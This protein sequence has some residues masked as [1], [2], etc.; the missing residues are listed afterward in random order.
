[1]ARWLVPGVLA[2]LVPLA[3]AAPVPLKPEPRLK[4][5]VLLPED[6][7]KI[8][9][10][11]EADALDPKAPEGIAPKRG[12]VAL[13]LHLSQNRYRMGQ[14]IPALFAVKNLTKKDL[15]L[16]FRLDLLETPPHFA[17]SCSVF[18]RNTRTNSNFSLSNTKTWECGSGALCGVPAEGFLALRGDLG[19]TP[20]GPLPVGDYV[21]HWTYGRLR[22]NAVRFTVIE[23]PTDGNPRPA[24]VV[25]VLNVQSEPAGQQARMLKKIEIE[26]DNRIEILDGTELAPVST[27]ELVQA[28]GA[29]VQGQHYPHLNEIPEED[30]LLRIRTKW[31]TVDKRDYVTIAF[32]SKNPDR[33]VSFQQMPTVFLILEGAGETQRERNQQEAKADRLDEKRA[34]LETPVSVEVRL[35]PNWKA[36]AGLSGPVRVSVLA[37]S[38]APNLDRFALKRL[39]Q[40]EKIK[41]VE[42]T[43]IWNG[44]LRSSERE[45]DFPQ[46][47]AK[48]PQ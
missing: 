20:N 39:Q 30:D 43:P 18:I 41:F 47:R 35:V 23:S 12:E 37:M 15:G 1:M 6:L 14:S 13:G 8:P 4:H 32:E 21:C 10:P 44:I 9:F 24:R 48:I 40:E 33:P 5:W 29:G 31:T 46:L 36:I 34:F 11:D 22:S 45:F 17:N 3:A 25:R 19:F 2:L 28:L 27:R 42:A 7:A 16:D 38:E 26:N